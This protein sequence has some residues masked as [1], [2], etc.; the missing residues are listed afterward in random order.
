MKNIFSY[1]NDPMCTFHLSAMH[2]HILVQSLKSQFTFFV[3]MR[4]WWWCGRHS[5]ICDL[6]NENAFYYYFY[7]LFLLNIFVFIFFFVRGIIT[8]LQASCLPFA[9]PLS[10]VLQMHKWFFFS[11]QR[12]RARNKQ[13]KNKLHF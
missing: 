11:V 3:A 12:C 4:L 7:S 2:K 5:E 13:H 1:F 10:C 6:G 9:K 8:Q